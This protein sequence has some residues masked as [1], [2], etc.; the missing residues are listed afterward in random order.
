MRIPPRSLT[1]AAIAGGVWIA[2]VSVR[3]RWMGPWHLIIALAVVALLAFVRGRSAVAMVA[4]LVA[5]GSL[6]SGQALARE[7]AILSFPVAAGRLDSSVRLLGDPRSG[8]FGWW[9][10]AVADPPEQGRPESIPMLLRFEEEPPGSAGDSIAVVGTRTP[11][12]GRISGSAYA[13]T[14]NVS[15]VSW[16]AEAGPVYWRVGNAIRART[17]DRLADR[18]PAGGL[19]A[20]FLVGDTDA[21]PEADL[22]A[23]R[24]SGLSH[25]VAVSGSNVALFL[26]VGVVVAGPLA[27]GPRR[28][29]AA[30]LVILVIVIVATRW[31]A[32]VVRAAVMAAIALLGR[33]GGWALDAL[34]A[35]AITTVLVLLVSAELATNVGFALSVL[36]TAGVVVATSIHTAMPRWLEVPLMATLG[37]QV[38]VAPI[39]L[40]VFGTVPLLAPVTNLL[41]A[42][43]VAITT[44]IGVAGVATGLDVVIG[45]GMLG[46]HFVLAVAR[47][48]AYWPQV[49]VVGSLGAGLVGLGVCFQKTRIAV[50]IGGA[51]VVA[52]SI[53]GVGV[54]VDR[55]AVV[56]LDIGQGDSIL[57]LG[58]EAT[59]LVDGG[60]DASALADK[61]AT[62][63]V[64]SLDLVVLTHV[65]ADHASGLTAVFGRIPVGEFWIPGPP[66]ETTA[67]RQALEA[68][69]SAGVR[70]RLPPVGDVVG[71]G[72]LSLEVLGP[73]RRY[74]GPNDQS[75]VLRIRSDG[76]PSLVL[77][78]DIETFAQADLVGLEGDILKVP[79]QG[80]ATSDLSWL[81]GVGSSQ[82]LISVGP[83]TFGH[84]SLEVI[85][86]LEGAG[87]EVL[88]TDE[89]GDIEVALGSP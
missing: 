60:P 25:L 52:G 5:L 72:D 18:G 68:A 7:D 45:I 89:V 36:A 82:A 12:T 49:G 14:V 17:L 67:S 4:L 62:Y 29:V 53:V 2:S 50:V 16:L 86:V 8:S 47:L 73:L 66:H 32:S 80:G 38:A 74:D 51:A 39:L 42:P 79:H 55:P 70:M 33:V 9:A 56:V 81:E 20:G 10:L 15:G 75:T 61:L 37:A 57:V 69:A 43:V 19:L 26:L 41:V 78:G 23:M 63:G 88:R 85:R 6:S 1:A 54:S 3:W 13:G 87:A 84:P 46:C 11:A 77:T 71:L 21:V 27:A 28:R 34:T 24:R 64:R 44:L 40:S 58:T 76:G 31:E 83:N 22:E 48:G 65:H 35:L 59:V 30:G